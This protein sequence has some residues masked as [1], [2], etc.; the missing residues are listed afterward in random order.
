MAL[1][2]VAIYSRLV[3]LRVTARELSLAGKTQFPADSRRDW[4]WGYEASLL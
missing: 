3:G 4:V 2:T 1:Y